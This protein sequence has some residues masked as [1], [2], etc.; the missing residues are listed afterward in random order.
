MKYKYEYK[1]LDDLITK[2]IK[3]SRARAIA[4]TKLEEAAMWAVKAALE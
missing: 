2:E 3:D 4:L 1:E